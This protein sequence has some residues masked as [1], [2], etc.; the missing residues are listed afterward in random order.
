MKILVAC[1]ESQAVTIELR[2][3]GHEAY[4]C[5]IIECSGGHP[6]WH[7]TQDVLPLLDG[8]CEF[9]SMDGQTH[10]IEGKWDMII[11]FPP[12]THLAVSG[13]AHFEKKRADGRQREAIEFFCQFL[14]ADC[15][16]ISIENPV[17]IIAGKYIPK[18]FPDLAEKYGLPRKPTQIVQPYEYGHAA[19]KTTCLWLKGLP[20]LI[21]TNVVDPGEF[22]T[23]PTGMKYSV[24]ASADMARDENGKIIPWN[25][26]RTALIRSKTYAG[27][28]KAM[29]EQWAGEV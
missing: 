22:Y 26:T 13:A 9:M 17:G 11:A 25:D 23:S 24:G 14:N 29:A 2:K 12:C 7:I 18:W 27:I 6:E 21:P 28:A 15:D 5:D 3:L 1:E 8:N 4:S 19:K 16:R 10:T 20:N